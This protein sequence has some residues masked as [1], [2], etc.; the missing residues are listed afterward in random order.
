MLLPILLVIAGF[1][2]IVL[3]AE[4]LV[5]SSAHIAKHFKVS[6]LLIGL[7]IVALGTSA[8]EI[9]VS[10]TAAINQKSELAMANA[11]GSNIANIGLVLGLSALVRPIYLQ[12]N[13]LLREIPILF[14]IMVSCYLLFLDGFFSFYDGA[15]LLIGLGLL[16]YFIISIAH[17]N[18]KDPLAQEISQ[19]LKSK[20]R[21]PYLRLIASLILLPLSAQMIVKGSIAIAAYLGVSEVVIGLTIVA[22]GT[23]LPEVVTSIMSIIKGEDDLAVGSIIGSNMFN[24]LAVLPFAGLI[25]PSHVPPAINYRDYPIMIGMSILLVLLSCTAQKS[26][27]RLGGA[28][29]LGLYISYLCLLCINA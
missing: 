13:T 25:A 3:A 21:Y 16:F 5:T 8:P 28:L 6:P 7:T 11:I 26:L 10:I 20:H 4:E 22:I 15:L 9:I 12:S 2:L 1:I 23:S 18:K 24:I 14:I 19:E 17:K 27:T 29:L